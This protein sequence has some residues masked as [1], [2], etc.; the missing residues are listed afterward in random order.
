M[1]ATYLRLWRLLL[2]R[3]GTLAL[4]MLGM[5]GAAAATGL[6][7]ILIGP[8]LKLIFATGAVTAPTWIGGWLGHFLRAQPPARLRS[9]LP[10]TLLLVAAFRA[11]FT[12]LQA[13]QMAE[14]CLRTVADLQEALHRK[15]LQ[16]PLSFFEGRHSGEV[17]AGFSN[18]LGHVERALT[19][20]VTYSLRDAFQLTALVWVSVALD[21]RLFLLGGCTLPIGVFAIA[22][23]AHALR[24]V[25][26][27]LQERQARLVAQAQ[28]LISGATVLQVYRAQAT[29]LRVEARAEDELLEVGRR[30]A[31]VRAAVTPTI[32]FLAQAA[33]ALVLLWMSL[34]RLDLPPEKVVSFF[35][36][37]ILAYQPLK[38][39]STNSQWIVPGLTAAARLF[40]L[41]DAPAAIADAPGARALA[42]KPGPIDLAFEGVTVR[43]GEREVLSD[44]NLDIRAGERVAIVGP[45][46]AGKSTLLHLLPRLLDPSSGVVRVA[47]QP[48]RELTL[49]SLRHHIGWVGQEVFL[50][51]ASVADNLRVGGAGADIDRAL[52]ASGALEFVQALPQGLDTRLGERGLRLSGGQRQRLSLARALMKQAP[53]L[54]LDEALSALEPQLEEEILDRLTALGSATLVL[55]THRLRTAERFDRVLVFE[56]GRLIE[57]GPPAALL[58][59]SGWFARAHAAGEHE[60]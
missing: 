58:R 39:I 14:L 15:L 32:E 7:A 19:Q 48:V 40:R 12:T 34:H 44:V 57:A 45:S 42:P 60:T 51:D 37:V 8:A 33:L 20:G 22:R 4:A 43:Y 41:L 11:G 24:G 28:D 52:A 3:P 2:R 36:A 31:I 49:R 55:V 25:S 26:I 35:G 54:L 21:W 17:F 59:S 18:D 16:L 27:E 23:F 53:L 6:F 5:A 10:L 13:R 50:F 30:S 38:S 47:G 9:A 29:A 56:Q 46:G 1:S